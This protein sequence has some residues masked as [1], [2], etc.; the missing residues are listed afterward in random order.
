M[1]NNLQ[2][3]DFDENPVRVIEK[4]GEPWFVA[5][6]V[7]RVLEYRDAEVACRALDE[8]EKGTLNVCTPGGNQE[9]KGINEM[10]IK[11]IGELKEEL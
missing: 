1:K 5:A 6:D 9:M 10:L 3:F 8:D 11:V 7:A 4:D 2:T